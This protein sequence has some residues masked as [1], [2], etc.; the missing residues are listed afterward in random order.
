MPQGFYQQEELELPHPPIS[1]S[2]FL[3]VEAALRATWELMRTKPSTKLQLLRADEDPVT[4]ELCERL[5]NEVF[6]RGVVE[7]FDRTLFAKPTRE[8]K[9]SNYDGKNPDKMPDLLIDLVD[10]P[11]VR[12]PAQDW[13]FIECKP[14]QSGRSAGAYYC[15]KGIIRFVHGDYAW[16]M[17]EALMVGYVTEECTISKKLIA[18][19]KKRGSTIPTVMSPEPCVHSP[20]TT[21]GEPTHITVHGRRFRYVQ[22]DQPAPPIRLRHL[23][24]RRD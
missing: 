4:C 11:V 20:A 22:N 1:P 9:V 2:V 3:V 6:N 17:G 23:W 16:A 5:C 10:R 13:L 12:I 21:C 24:L 19:L 7:G 15:D 8:T 14:V 18:A